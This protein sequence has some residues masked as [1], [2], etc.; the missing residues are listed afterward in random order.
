MEA[1]ISV[2]NQSKMK[3][4][5]YDTKLAMTPPQHNMSPRH[6]WLENC[7]SFWDGLLPG[8]M[9]KIFLLGDHGHFHLGMTRK[10]TPL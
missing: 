5:K 10:E 3:Q 4:I 7:I 2:G 1:W 8:P 6:V 9:F